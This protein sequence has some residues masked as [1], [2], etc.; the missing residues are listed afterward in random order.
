MN[1]PCENGALG[2]WPSH[3]ILKIA[4]VAVGLVLTASPALAAPTTPADLDQLIT[5]L[6]VMAGNC[7]ASYATASEE[8]AD[9][10]LASAKTAVESC[11]NTI[12]DAIGTIQHARSQGYISAT[13]AAGLI[14]QYTL[15]KARLT[16]AAKNGTLDYINATI[17][18]DPIVNTNSAGLV[19]RSKSEMVTSL[20]NAQ[21]RH[22]A[23]LRNVNRRLKPA[24]PQLMLAADRPSLYN[25][26]STVCWRVLGIPV[27]DRKKTPAS[28]C[29]ITVKGINPAANLGTPRI[30]AIAGGPDDSITAFDMSPLLQAPGTNPCSGRICFALAGD[31]GGGNIQLF[32]DNGMTNEKVAERILFNRG[33]GR[34]DPMTGIPTIGLLSGAS[35]FRGTYSGGWNGTYT[36]TGSEDLC[37]DPPGTT[38]SV[39]GPSGA[40]ISATGSIQVTAPGTGSGTVTGLGGYSTGSVSVPPGSSKFIGAIMTNRLNDSA[41]ARGTW[42]YSDSCGKATGTWYADRPSP[43][44]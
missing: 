6:N 43:P 5:D 22:E 29:P 30:K 3:R 25:A 7:I 11:I 40:V 12:N 17:N 28:N 21:T 24:S 19:S 1:M 39:S 16:N 14:L 2:G 37:G 42:S 15:A 34:P 20:A 27:A 32:Y 33:D 26:G 35:Q 10:D 36:F 13:A 4:L 23:T 18:S 8:L 44:S 31:M 9:A 38:M 41:K